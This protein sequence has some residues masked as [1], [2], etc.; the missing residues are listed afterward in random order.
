[1]FLEHVDAQEEPHV[2]VVE[3]LQRTFDS[4]AAVDPN[5]RSVYSADD[6]SLSDADSDALKSV[7][8]VFRDVGSLREVQTD[9]GRLCPGVDESLELV[10]VDFHRNVEHCRWNE[11]LGQVFFCVLAVVSNKRYRWLSNLSRR[12]LASIC[13]WCCS[14]CGVMLICDENMLSAGPGLV[15]GGAGRGGL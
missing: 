3:Y 9:D 2:E 10:A 13:C 5:L 8:D 7:V 11:G 14:S 4:G 1:M 6:L 12:I 15:W